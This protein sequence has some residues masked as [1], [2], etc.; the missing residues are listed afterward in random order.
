MDTVTTAEILLN[1][2]TVK[3]GKDILV[4]NRFLTQ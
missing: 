4:V 3:N 1:F 2:D